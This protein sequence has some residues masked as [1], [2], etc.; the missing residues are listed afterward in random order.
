MLYENHDVQR[1]L[2]AVVFAATHDDQAVA[3][4]FNA[5]L[6]HLWAVETEFPGQTLSW[7]LQNCKSFARDHLKEGKSVDSRKR[8]SHLGEL[9]EE[10][11]TVDD[12]FAFVS[13]K[14]ILSELSRRLGPIDRSV[15]EAMVRGD[16][17]KEIARDCGVSRQA[18]SKRRRRITATARTLLTDLRDF[19][20]S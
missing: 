13:A 2:R 1:E 15:L 12:T 9:S 20:G 5:A 14:D 8:R 10:M 18:V 6:A 19:V 3:D 11:T 17:E 16:T 7:Y 4:L